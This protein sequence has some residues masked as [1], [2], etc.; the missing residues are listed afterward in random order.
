MDKKKAL[1]LAV[2]MA[3]AIP[4]LSYAAKG[5]EEGG[6]GK[7]DPDSVVTLYGKLYP[8]IAHSRGKDATAAG[9]STCTI[10]APAA[11]SNGIT[12]RTLIE[13]PNTRLGVRGH[14]KLGGDL[15]AIFQLETEFRIDQNDTGFAQRDSFV[16]LDHKRWGTV[17]LGR[18][19]TPF[20]A[21]GDELSFLGVSSGNFTST[22]NV[23]RKTGFGTNSASS[24]HLRRQNA[25]Q[26]ETPDFA[27][28]NGAVQYSTDETDTPTRHPHVWSGA[29]AW[30]GGPL[31][32]SLAYEQHWDL[33]G[34]SRNVPSAQSN[35]NDQNVRSK[36]KAWQAMILYKLGGHRFEAD[37]IQKKY[38]E[39][40][41][42][43]G[44]FSNYKNNAYEL[45]W[46]AR[47]SRS[48]RTQ[49]EYIKSLKGSCSR[50]NAACTTDGLDG[51]QVN[52]GVAYYFSRRTYAFLMAAWLKNDH[53]ARYSNEFTQSPNPGEDI[54]IYALGI[55]HSF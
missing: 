1:V 47:W 54:L 26:Y 29:I 35:F 14:E 20:K 49:I 25:A 30:E 34:G 22:S 21:Y 23:L 44:R 10:C 9:Q 3:L 7:G 18:M 42:I 40:A 27:G 37:Y 32:V 4:A 8:E 36:D 19:D 51:Q 6:D 28:F 52:A 41:T 48:W 43:T 13:A 53:S 45:I 38:D 15:R 17:K 12:S 31:R 5:D 46:D 24:F 50:V 33:F 55:N 39:N 16:G 2:S 11:G